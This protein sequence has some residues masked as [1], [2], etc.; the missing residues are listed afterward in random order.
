[1]SDFL[2]NLIA[3]SFIDAPLIQPRVPSL[4]ETA[5]D[6]FFDEPPS[7]ESAIA[8]PETIAPANAPAAASNSLSI[9]GTP[10]T[11]PV[12]T[13][14]DGRAEQHQHLLKPD[15]PA[16]ENA[17]V[18]AQPPQSGEQ[19][20]EATKL[21]VK[22]KR[23]LVPLSSFRAEEKET[24]KKERP[25]QAFSE[26]RPRHSRR[27][28]DFSSAEPPSSTSPPIIRVTIGRVEVRA[29]H[30][31]PSAPKP[32]KNAPPKLSLEDYLRERQRSSR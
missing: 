18:T 30:P 11:K 22:T 14:S 32:A 31:P 3:R 5:A 25:A 6:E 10:T 2:S 4:F 7:V 26:P 29:I 19:A 28:K 9:K 16:D 8:A 12:A 21:E 13:V 20:T 15:V 17:T 27:R 24:E 1:M 23:I